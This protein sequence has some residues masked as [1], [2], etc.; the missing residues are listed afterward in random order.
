MVRITRLE[1]EIRRNEEKEQKWR[2][3]AEKRRRTNR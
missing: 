1:K 2:E 3:L